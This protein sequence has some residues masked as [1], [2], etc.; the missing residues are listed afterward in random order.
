MKKW[1]RR[2]TKENE[3]DEKCD[4]PIIYSICHN[5][6]DRHEQVKKSFLLDS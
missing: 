1:P 6:M 3:T 2:A 5:E 4:K